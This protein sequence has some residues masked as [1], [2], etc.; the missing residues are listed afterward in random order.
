MRK[1][2]ND[3]GPTNIYCDLARV[4]SVQILKLWI[5]MNNNTGSVSLLLPPGRPRSARIKANIVMAKQRPNQ[6]KRVSTR[7]IAVEFSISK[8]NAQRILPEDLD[9]VPY[10]K[11]RQPKLTHLQKQNRLKFASWVLNNY[12]KNDTEG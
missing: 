9:C 8:N 12:T 1:H 3:D 5:K 11:I 4:I 10:K 7:R 6:E 2:E